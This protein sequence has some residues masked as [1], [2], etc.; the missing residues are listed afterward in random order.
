MPSTRERSTRNRFTL[1]AIV[2]GGGFVALGACGS[3]S[4][5]DTVGI[6]TAGD[7][8]TVGGGCEVPAQGCPCAPNGLTQACKEVL[9]NGNYTSCAK[10]TLTCT[11]GTWGA[12]VTSHAMFKSLGPVGG[13]GG[14]PAHPQNLQDAA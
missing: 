14:Q 3:P 9:H 13:G 10:G 5:P 1:A 4:N 2:A 11:G 12:C 8:V 7:D 6:T